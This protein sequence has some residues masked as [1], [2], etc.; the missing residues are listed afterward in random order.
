MIYGA[1]GDRNIAR[2][3]QVLR[4]TPVM[5]VPGGG[6]RLQQPVHVEDLARAITSAV[7]RDEAVGHA[8]D[9]P[10]PLPLPFRDL[11]L[12]AG[13]AVGRRPR[14]LP[15]PMAPTIAALR[16]YERAARSPRIKAEQLER[17]SEDKTFDAGP[18]RELLAYEGR[19]FTDGVR[20]EAALLGFR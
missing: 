6:H 16:A 8:I 13:D 4:K 19:S 10:G 15:V 9:V 12:A 3:L 17:L 5:P 18:A 14:L 2:L 7:E 20:H 1:P 11:L